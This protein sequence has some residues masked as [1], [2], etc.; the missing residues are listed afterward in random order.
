MTP[1]QDHVVGHAGRPL[2]P[3]RKDGGRGRYNKGYTER[4][5]H[6]KADLL[7]VHLHVLRQQRVDEKARRVDLCPLQRG[8]QVTP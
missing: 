5:V 4:P 1:L 6:H 7:E 3:T 2:R 8:A